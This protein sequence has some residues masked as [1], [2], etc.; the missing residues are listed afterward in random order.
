[1]LN[2][3]TQ[4]RKKIVEIEYGGY[5]SCCSGAI[6][7]VFVEYYGYLLQRKEH[8]NDTQFQD[9]LAV[10]PRLNDKTKERLEE[11]ISVEE[12]ERAIDDLPMETSPGHD[13]LTVAI[14]KKYKNA[15]AGFFHAVALEV[16]TERTYDPNLKN[17]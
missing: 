2:Q 9:H 16:N 3:G 17:S 10:M 15:V 8:E 7:K 5:A 14:H 13:G 12:I 4:K 11:P 1:M 6:R